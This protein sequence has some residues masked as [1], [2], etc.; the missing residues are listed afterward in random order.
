MRNGRSGAVAGSWVVGS[1]AAL[2]MQGAISLAWGRRRG[3]K[4]RAPHSAKVGT[5]ALHCGGADTGKT[6][7]N[8]GH[9][10]KSVK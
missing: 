7:V 4:P 6:K 10:R 9:L 3:R 8:V 1:V 2:V 5:H